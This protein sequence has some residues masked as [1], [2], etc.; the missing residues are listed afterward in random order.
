MRLRLLTAAFSL[1]DKRSAA[2]VLKALT[3]P[4]G[5]QQQHLHKRFLNIDSNFRGP[6]LEI[7]RE[8][9]ATKTVAEAKP[10]GMPPATPPSAATP[11]WIE[12]QPGI[13]ALVP[14]AGTTLDAVAASVSD[15]PAVPPALAR[16]NKLSRTTPIEAGQ[17]VI[18]P[19]EFIQRP[20]A[21]E[22]MSEPMRRHILSSQMAEAEN[23]QLRRSIQV[24]SPNLPGPG[25][26][27]SMVLAAKVAVRPIELTAAAIGRIVDALIGLIEKAGYA[28]AFGAGVVHGFFKAIWDA[29][30]GIAKLI[31]EVLKSIFSLDLVSDLEKIIGALKKLTLEQ[32]KQMLGEWAAGW[33]EKLHSTNPLIAGHAHG[34]LTGYVMAEAAMLLFDRRCDRGDWSGRSGDLSS[35]AP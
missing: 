30:S 5:A 29:V 18:V 1:L 20:K 3:K 33:A 15:N 12:L 2:T 14:D 13:F 7:L 22:Q 8:R 16:L 25:I 4:A 23:P 27:G 6:L 11:K 17:S 9:A 28:I 26:G 34:Y 31:Y 19:L 10:A 21:L 24:R 32:I 35:A